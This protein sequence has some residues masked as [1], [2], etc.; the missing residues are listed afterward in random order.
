MDY[1]TISR[2]TAVV[3]TPV[4]TLDSRSRDYCAALQIQ[5]EEYTEA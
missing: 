4:Y 3:K 5:G 1:E 2:A